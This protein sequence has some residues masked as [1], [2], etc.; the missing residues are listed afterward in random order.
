ME[1]GID[2]VRLADPRWVVEQANTGGA[3]RDHKYRDRSTLA[4]FT[5]W[6]LAADQRSL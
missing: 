1:R 5:R 4:L 6:I 2:R 3:G